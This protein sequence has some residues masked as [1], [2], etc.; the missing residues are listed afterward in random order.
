MSTETTKLAGPVTIRPDSEAQVALE[1]AQIIATSETGDVKKDR[2]YWLTLYHQCRKA[3]SS[4]SV[5]YKLD[6]IIKDSDQTAG[7]N[8]STSQAVRS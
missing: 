8:F 4:T 2:E 6:A 5:Y 3:T 7:G 1:L